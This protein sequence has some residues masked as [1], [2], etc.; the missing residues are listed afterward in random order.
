[1]MERE[2]GREIDTL[3]TLMKRGGRETE[4]IRQI[5]CCGK[6]LIILLRGVK[7]PLNRCYV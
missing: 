6:L 1:M 4:R 7:L 5:L 2:R 3:L